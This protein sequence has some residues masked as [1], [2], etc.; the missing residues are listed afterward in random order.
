M[1]EDAETTP[2]TAAEVETEAESKMADSALD[3]HDEL[4][5]EA[6]EEHVNNVNKFD[7][8]VNKPEPAETEA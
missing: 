8:N 2:T 1:D 6:E 7:D 5:F 4:D 3:D